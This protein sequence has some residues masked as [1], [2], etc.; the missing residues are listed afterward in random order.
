M[1]GCEIPD[2]CAMSIS[3]SRAIERAIEVYKIESVLEFGS[4][5]STYWFAKRVK[6]V[7]T[8]EWNYIWIPVPLKNI[9]I[10]YTPRT[11]EHYLGSLNFVPHCDLILIDCSR[12]DWRVKIYET[13]KDWDWKVLCIHDFKDEDY[14]TDLYSGVKT[15]KYDSLRMY[16][17]PKEAEI[18]WT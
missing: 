16:F 1:A 6:S 17:K 18:K 10:I 3:C 11:D 13:V 12:L 15:E 14:P 7:Y 4:G 5:F 2:K 9:T 8:V